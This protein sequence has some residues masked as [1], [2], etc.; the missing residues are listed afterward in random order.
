VDDTHATAQDGEEPPPPVHHDPDTTLELAQATHVCVSHSRGWAWMLPMDPVTLLPVPDATITRF[1]LRP[2]V[3]C[4]VGDRI[5]LEEN[6]VVGVAHRTGS[7]TRA[8]G[9]KDQLMAANLQRLVVVMA[10]GRSL[11]E[12]FLMRGLIACALQSIQP[13]VVLNKM[14]LDEDGEGEETAARWEALG[15]TV[16]RTSAATGAGLDALE[17][18]IGT[19]VSAMMG[20]SGVGKS[21]LINTLRPGANRRT[22]KLDWQGKGRH[23]TTQA[24]AI[25]RAGSMLIDLPGV[26]EFGISGATQE[27]ILLAFPDVKAA[28]ERCT[29]PNC[30]HSEEEGCGLWAAVDDGSLDALRV[31]L[32][33]RMQESVALGMEGG[34]RV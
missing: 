18:V 7:L 23:I 20:F 32:C 34:G 15:V 16:V 25:V 29:Y 19:G 1:Q 2:G 3:Y 14:D 8:V 21:T 13:V 10:V 24:E 17:A 30:S 5:R 12:G 26:R 6:Y 31:E 11:R 28:M 22:G 27:S 33:L 4:V 9:H